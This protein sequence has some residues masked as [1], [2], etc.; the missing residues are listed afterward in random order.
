MRVWT[1]LLCVLL[2]MACFPPGARAAEAGVNAVATLA[3]AKQAPTIDGKMAEGEW[4]H[5][6]MM[7]PFMG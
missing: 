5:A 2:V 1:G 7:Q 3:K 4:D 6:L